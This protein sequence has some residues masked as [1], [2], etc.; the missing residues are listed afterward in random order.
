M[1]I[2]LIR[3]KFNLEKTYMLRIGNHLKVQEKDGSMRV[4]NAYTVT[5]KGVY[6]NKFYAMKMPNIR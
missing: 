2:I 1:Y 4:K 6:L 3:S 5:T